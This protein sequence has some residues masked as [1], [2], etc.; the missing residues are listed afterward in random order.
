MAPLTLT[1]FADAELTTA[2][3]L[4][5]AAQ[6]ALASTLDDLAAAR[7]AQAQAATALEALARDEADLRAKLPLVPMPGDADALAQALE[8]AIVKSRTQQAIVVGATEDLALAERRAELAQA[9]LGWATAQDDRAVAAKADAAA[10]AADLAK[11]ATALAAP[12][13]STLK[14]AASDALKAP[15][16]K[17]AKKRVD[18]DLPSDLAARAR[19]QRAAAVAAVAAA[20]AAAAKAQDDAA[21]DL[22][23]HTGDAGIVVPL[24]LALDRAEAAYRAALRGGE[25]FDEANAG[26]AQV[27]AAAPL[28]AGEQ[29]RIAD[30]AKTGA[31]AVDVE[32]ARAALAAAT[33]ASADPATDPAV[34]DAKTVLDKAEDKLKAAS[35]TGSGDEVAEIST[36]EA[37]VPDGVWHE[38]D[39]FEASQT[40]L[41]ELS[42]FDPAGLGATMATAETAYVTA[43]SAAAAAA[44]ASH[45][46]AETAVGAI[47]TADVAVA[48]AAS[49]TFSAVRGD[50]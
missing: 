39:D 20:E 21:K 27:V 16:F 6:A 45:A 37:T 9:E 40:T 47:A 22:E 50:G 11:V 44:R 38:L 10:R 12:P 8:L 17:Q 33:A 26:L 46:L 31:A 19:V 30:R 18:D 7:A 29:A 48:L 25:R 35:A 13:L 28:T 14:K 42:G 36:W 5:A 2:D 41:T 15:L 1:E 43:A 23:T 24:R 34:A 3:G 4:L 32:K 49:R